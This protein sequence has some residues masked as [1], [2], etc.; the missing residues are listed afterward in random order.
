MG[1]QIEFRAEDG[2]LLHGVLHAREGRG[3][4]GLVMTH[5]FAAAGEPKRLVVHPGGH[6]DTYRDH[7]AETSDAALQW[8]CEHLKPET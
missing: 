7:F 8:F 6:F 1:K 5:A 4:Q 2:T 3:P